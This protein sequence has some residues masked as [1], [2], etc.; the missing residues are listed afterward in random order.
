M[1]FHASELNST[2]DIEDNVVINV[3]VRQEW[4]GEGGGGRLHAA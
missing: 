1:V 3:S 2:G 4:V